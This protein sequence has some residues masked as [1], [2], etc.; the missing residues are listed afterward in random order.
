MAE[1]ESAAVI[2]HGP[3]T[4]ADELQDLQRFQADLHLVPP[5]DLE[6]VQRVEVA[7][8]LP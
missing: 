1:G 7:Q 5:L 3:Q 4:S 6:R 8:L 2:G